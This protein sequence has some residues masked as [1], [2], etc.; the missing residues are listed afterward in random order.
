MPTHFIE[1][2]VN[3][4]Y[5]QNML[6]H[7]SAKTTE[8]YIKTIHINN[9]NIESSLDSILENFSSKPYMPYINNRHIQ[10]LAASSQNETNKTK[11]YF[12]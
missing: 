10:L 6:G 8:I 9:K 11:T 5:L 2:N 3:L 1:N 7:N 12:R 4:R